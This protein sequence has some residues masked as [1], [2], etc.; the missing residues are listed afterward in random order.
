MLDLACGTI[1]SQVFD[2][3]IA[4][5]FIGMSNPSLAAL[6]ERVLGIRVAKGHRLTDWLARPLD[7]NQLVYAA[8]D[9]EH[10][11]AAYEKLLAELEGRGRLQWVLD[12]CEGVRQRERGGRDPEQA[13]RRVKEIRQLRGTARQR[14]PGGGRVAG[15]AGRRPPDQPVRHVLPD[16]AIVGIAQR[17]P[18]TPEQLRQVRGLDDRHLRGPQVAEILAAIA[19]GSARPPLPPDEPEIRELDRDLRPAVAA[20]SRRG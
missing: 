16:L 18:T 9:V 3:Q 12:E 13:W 17:H 2:T 7:D 8:G 14:G 15:S 20:R 5:G 10:L 6:Y 1:P 11:L 4:A 19:A